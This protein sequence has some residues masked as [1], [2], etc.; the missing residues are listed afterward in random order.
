MADPETTPLILFSGLAADST[1]FAPQKAEFPQLIVPSWRT[2]TR[3]DTLD[4]YARRFAE[5]FEH[6][7]NPVIG[8]ASFGGIVALHVAQYLHPSLIILI[9]SVRSPQELSPWIR[10]AR[11]L[12]HLVPL[13]PVKLL[14]IC[15][16]PLTFQCSHKRW[17]H[18]SGLARQFV[19]S[20]PSTLRW[21]LAQLLRWRQPMELACPIRQI[22]GQQDRILPVRF[23]SPDVT[24]QGGHVISLINSSDVNRFIRNSLLMS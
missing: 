12:H 6:L 24:V 11:L 21:S 4:S 13:I 22:H 14:Q 9:G 16:M 20:D 1:I 7:E 15:A 10:G 8:G 23:T 19:Y 3:S 17:P 2:P 18:L 5:E